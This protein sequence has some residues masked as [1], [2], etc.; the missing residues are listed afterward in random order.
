VSALLRAAVGSKDETMLAQLLAE[1]ERIKAAIARDKQAHEMRLAEAADAI[2]RG[3]SEEVDPMTALLLA[4][5]ADRY[6][7]EPAPKPAKPP[8]L[9]APDFIAGP[10]S[11]PWSAFKPQ[12]E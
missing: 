10:N 6:D 2:A 5:K 7:A 3:D 9:P 4:V 12:E 1:A 11:A 8:P